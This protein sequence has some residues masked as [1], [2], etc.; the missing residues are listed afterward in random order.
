MG[1][2]VLKRVGTD[3]WSRPVYQSEKGYFY[4]DI[5]IFS[6][7][8]PKTLYSSCPLNDFEGEPDCPFTDFVIIG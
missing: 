7:E 8:I 4:K 1:K 3:Y 6:E 5:D 2:L